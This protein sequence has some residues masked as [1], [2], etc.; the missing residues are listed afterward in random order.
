MDFE[1]FIARWTSREGGAERANVQMYLSELCDVIG[2]IRPDPAGYEHIYNDYVFERAVRRRDSDDT[3]S[4]LRIDLYKRGCFI[5][6]AKQSRLPGGYKALPNV[7]PD[8]RSLQA[9]TGDTWDAAL[10]AGRRQAENYVFLLEPDHVAPPFLIICD[11]GNVFEIYADFTGTGRA[12]SQFPDRNSFRIHITDLR[13][14]HVREMLSKIWSDP[15]SLD[16]AR[17]SARV[18]ASV[19]QRLAAVS[20][21]LEMR[22]DAGEVALF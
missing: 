1:A 14:P 5:L 2:V 12:Y 8:S 15:T 6:E 3:T 11:V 16:P 17:L 13:K 4:S 21:S 18:T 19:A 9:G 10:R 20:R 22:Y 7:A